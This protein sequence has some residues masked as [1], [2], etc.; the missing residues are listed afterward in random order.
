MVT[1]TKQYIT[2]IT[3]EELLLIEIGRPLDKNAMT[4]EE[5]QEEISIY[6]FEKGIIIELIAA[7]AF[8]NVACYHWRT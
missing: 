8:C 4:T 2:W 7:S 5:A 1:T 3:E 6:E